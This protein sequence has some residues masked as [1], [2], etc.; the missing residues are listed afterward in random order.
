MVGP[1]GERGGRRQEQV[2]GFELTRDREGARRFDHGIY[3]E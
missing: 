3:I 2:G 1:E